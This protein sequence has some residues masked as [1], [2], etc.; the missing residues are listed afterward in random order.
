MKGKALEQRSEELRNEQLIEK[1][2]VELMD[3]KRKRSCDVP[4][5]D[6]VK[7]R[8]MDAQYF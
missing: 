6:D 5:P 1:E 3:R 8:R 2:T 4:G 7:I